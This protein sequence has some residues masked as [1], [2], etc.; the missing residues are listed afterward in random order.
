MMNISATLIFESLHAGSHLTIGVASWTW[1][2]SAVAQN[3]KRKLATKS[4]IA[5][6]LDPNLDTQAGRYK[7]SPPLKFTVPASTFRPCSTCG[8]CSLFFLPPPPLP[9]AACLLLL[10]LLLLLLQL[11]NTIII[12]SI[13]SAYTVLEDMNLVEM[14]DS[15]VGYI[16]EAAGNPKK[17][18]GEYS[19]NADPLQE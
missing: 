9:P 7:I 3:L 5:S 13:T 6:F 2:T 4:C 15:S 12:A 17:N 8:S 18:L 19:S 10:L 1:S 16:S 14:F 11:V